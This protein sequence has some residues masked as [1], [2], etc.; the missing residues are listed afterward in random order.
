MAEPVI[1]EAPIFTTLCNEAFRLRRQV[2]IEEQMIPSEEEFEPVDLTARHFVAIED[3]EVC[4]T[5]RV[6]V[7]DEHVQI[8][9]LAVSRHCRGRGVARRMVAHAMDVFAEDAKGR[10]YLT[11][12][13]DKQG[14]YERF[15]FVGFGEV[16]MDGGIP[17]LCMKTY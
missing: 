6:V 17:H 14:F 11:A 9:R 3:G 5:F 12:Q 7:V 8:G 16:F 2:F 10:F 4:A 15:G 1:V 13:A